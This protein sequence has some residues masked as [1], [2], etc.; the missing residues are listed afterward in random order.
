MGYLVRILVKYKEGILD[1][2]IKELEE[3]IKKRGYNIKHF[4]SGKHF[5]YISEKETEKEVEKEANDI[6]EKFLLYNPLNEKFEVVSIKKQDDL[7]K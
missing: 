4:N 3:S 5:S 1:P 2:E 7:P 6:S